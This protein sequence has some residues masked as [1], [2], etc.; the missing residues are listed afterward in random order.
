MGYL[1]VTNDD[2]IDSPS[3]VPFMQALSALAPARAV[4]PARERSWIGKAIT[5]FDDIR[6]ETTERDG[7]EI[8]VA[9][10][11]PAD[12]VQLGVHSLFDERPEMVVSGINLGLNHGR[13]FLLSSGTVGAA[14]EGSIAGLPAVAFSTGDLTDQVNWG[15]FAWS[16]SPEELWDRAASVA[17]DVLASIRAIG[18]PTDVDVLSVNYPHEAD[19]TTPRALTGLARTG[20][21][22]IFNESTPGLYAHAFDGGLRVEEPVAGTDH[23]ALQRGQ[24]AITPIRLAHTAQPDAAFRAAFGG[25]EATTS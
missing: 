22:S 12:C 1:L 21:D 4:V 10:G 23:E 2:G 11:F 16:A 14:A 9:D 8:H 18:F 19:L 5:R 7:V 24:V 15:A 20:Y 17:V 13:A 3:L 6:V 25:D